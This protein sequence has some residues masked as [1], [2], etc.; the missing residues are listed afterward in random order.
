M[1][2]RGGAFV[3][4]AEERHGWRWNIPRRVFVS[5]PTAHCGAIDAKQASRPGLRKAE[6][7][8][9]GAKFFVGHFAIQ[10]R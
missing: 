10:L 5:E 8:E 6:A 9:D 3:D 1:P 4:Q 7:G 2:E